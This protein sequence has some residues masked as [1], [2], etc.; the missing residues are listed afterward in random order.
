VPGAGPDRPAGPPP[1]P[2][3]AGPPT[4]PVP[5]GELLAL[6]ELGLRL[7]AGP[8][9]AGTVVQW[10]H[11]S[12]MADPRPWLLGGE[13]LL[14]A[15]V[16]LADP[17][18]D[19][20]RYAERIVAAGAAALGFGVTPVHDTVPP[21]LVAA[22]ER[23]GLPLIEVPPA[24]TFTAVARAVWRLMARARE[25]ELRRIARAQQGLATAAARADPVPAVLRQLA[26]HVDGRAVLYGRGGTVLAAAG[27]ASRAAEDAL[28][29]LARVVAPPEPGAPG[30]PPG[31]GDRGGAR[32]PVDGSAPGAAGSGA[33]RAGETG[34]ARSG[35][36]SG[37]RGPGPGS[38]GPRPDTTG[39]T[40]PEGAAGTPGPFEHPAPAGTAHPTGEPAGP[41]LRNERSGRSG[42][43]ESVA[44]A[45]GSP[46]A[47]HG[48]PGAGNTGPVSAPPPAAV[49]L[50]ASDTAGGSRLSAYALGGG[51]GLALGL[52]APGRDPGD[53]TLAGV[54]AVLLSL[55]TAVPRGPEA[56]GRNSALVRLLLGESPERAAAALGADRWTV[57]RA[58]P[59]AP[60]PAPAGPDTPP[61]DRD[62]SVG[63]FTAAALGT[64]LGTP[65]VDPAGDGT[66]RALLPPG[67]EVR[68]RPGWLI[69]ASVPAGP[70]GLPAADLQARHALERATATR[71]ALVRHRRSTVDA[72]LPPEE[73]AAHARLVLAPLEDR[74]ELRETLRLWLSLHGG[75]EPTATA[76][77]LHRN[78]VRQRIARC[79][80]LLGEDLD[81]PDVRME[82]WFA[83][84][85]HP[86][87]SPGPGGV[88]ADGAAESGD[89][90]A[91]G[92]GGGT[93]AP[94]PGRA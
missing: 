24:T 63:A 4:P 29:G 17:A 90:A 72:L 23:H 67:A 26:A 11:T 21:A 36:S 10:V 73:A 5:L 14:S 7:I 83:L 80:A 8:P 53:H 71:R 81:D 88:T 57:L 15:G 59:S 31:T 76:A 65:L 64:A 30:A 9:A 18:A 62:R 74:P 82:L 40:A 85:Q 39:P 91:E 84:R 34:A 22:C 89:G 28:A 70:A 58:R 49:P 61:A 25:R 35:G 12:E 69:G 60:E 41:A 55:L 75:W 32:P 54:A 77:G 37:A 2:D 46:P 52:A 50:S 93:P 13:L 86:G 47:R 19:A 68:E 33:G 1:G 43:S 3:P 56:A 6:R 38:R 44:S 78:T 94:G 20:G 92:G 45:S 42:R 87:G 27:R 48:G 79:A 66:V 51:Q 16:P